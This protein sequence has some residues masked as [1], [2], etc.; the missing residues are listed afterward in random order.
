LTSR[1]IGSENNLSIPFHSLELWPALPA[2]SIENTA[3]VFGVDSPVI[4][5]REPAA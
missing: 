5:Q 4:C 2:V 3:Q 1:L